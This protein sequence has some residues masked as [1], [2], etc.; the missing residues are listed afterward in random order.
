[1]GAAILGSRARGA[2]QLWK[3]IQNA[4]DGSRR[5]RWCCKKG[6]LLTRSDDGLRAYCMSALEAGC[7]AGI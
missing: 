3:S 7:V 6:G 4:V 1:V 2:G 5:R